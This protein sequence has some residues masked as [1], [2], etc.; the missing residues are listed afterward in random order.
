MAE[1]TRLEKLFSESPRG[2]MTE[3]KLQREGSRPSAATSLL[4]YVGERELRVTINLP[5]FCFKFL[6]FLRF[7]CW[8]IRESERALISRAVREKLRE[9][10][11]LG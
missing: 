2:L 8:A 1:E 4:T 6:V 10:T 9:E 3:L 7:F 5:R 11:E